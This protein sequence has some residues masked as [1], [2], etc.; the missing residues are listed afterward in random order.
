MTAGPTYP[1]GLS[2]GS[3]R[4]GNVAETMLLVVALLAF[5]C[6]VGLT[7]RRFAARVQW[8]LLAGIVVLVMVDF[9][10]RALP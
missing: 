9:A 2:T 8:L 10:R 6:L 3:S 4:P 5:F 7:A 1:P